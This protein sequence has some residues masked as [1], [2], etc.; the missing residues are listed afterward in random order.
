MRLQ[1]TAGQQCL[2][3]VHTFLPTIGG[4][5]YN[6]FVQEW[7]EPHH[8]FAPWYSQQHRLNQES[9]L[10]LPLSGHQTWGSV[11]CYGD[12]AQSRTK[13]WLW[14]PEVMVT[15]HMISK[16]LP[17]KFQGSSQGKQT[18]SFWKQNSSTKRYTL[19]ILPDLLSSFTTMWLIGLFNF[20][21]CLKL[22]FFTCV[23]VQPLVSHSCKQLFWIIMLAKI[24]ISPHHWHS[25]WIP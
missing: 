1:H 21:P 7:I 6:A 17:P 23:F 19:R 12:G 4:T 9:S 10:L 13:A 24:P 20:S 22:S 16:G 5:V 18:Y 25:A 2:F 11:G 3:T 14:P 8:E 15:E